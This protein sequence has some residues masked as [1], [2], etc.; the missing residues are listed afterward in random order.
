MLSSSAARGDDAA[1]GAGFLLFNLVQLVPGEVALD[2]AI[3]SDAR[4]RFR[5][6]WTVQIPLG[7]FDGRQKSA[8]WG[9]ETSP[10]WRHRVVASLSLAYGSEGEAAARAL[11]LQTVDVR[12]GYR[13]RFR[14]RH[15]LAPYFGIGV[16]A[17]GQA[18][19]ARV[20]PGDGAIYLS[21]EFGIHAGGDTVVFWPGVQLGVQC[22]VFGDG[23]PTRI[24]GVVAWTLW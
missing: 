9:N 6:A 5:L 23:S 19:D 20:A 21:P 14:H 7:A 1:G 15:G 17:Q 24:Q 10:L 3:S 18:N 2:R 11:T 16:G 22:S 13:Y 8:D 12:T 4:A